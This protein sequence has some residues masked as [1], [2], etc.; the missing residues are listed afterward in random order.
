MNE[1]PALEMVS[2]GTDATTAEA[3]P[4]FLGNSIAVTLSGVSADLLDRH[5]RGSDQPDEIVGALYDVLDAVKPAALNGERQRQAFVH[6]LAGTTTVIVS[7]A[8]PPALHPTSSP[9]E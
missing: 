8:L 9:H 4:L 5:L 3:E 6:R 2:D 1:R 7:V